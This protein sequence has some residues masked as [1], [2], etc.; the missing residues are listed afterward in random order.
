M[1]GMSGVPRASRSCSSTEAFM[2]VGSRWNARSAL[3][4]TLS[5]SSFPPPFLEQLK[6][7]QRRSSAERAAAAR[8]LKQS[9]ARRFQIVNA[10]I[11]RGE[12]T[13]RRG[14]ASDQAKML[15]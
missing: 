3:K 14:R 2:M 11:L 6:Q 7:Q 15:S 5:A 9:L 10:I 1:S 12:R 8:V 4:R 13:R